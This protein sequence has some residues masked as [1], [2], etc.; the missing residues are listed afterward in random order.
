M[1]SNFI[2]GIIGSFSISQG[3]GGDGNGSGKKY[4]STTG[5]PG[6]KLSH[7]DWK[8]NAKKGMLADSH[9]QA[10]QSTQATQATHEAH[11]KA[12]RDAQAA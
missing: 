5:A 6:G 1:A 9:A 10:A 11:L 2:S 7:K 8:K 12:E 3:N 4:P